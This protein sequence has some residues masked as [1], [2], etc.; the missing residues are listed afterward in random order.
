V[1]LQHRPIRQSKQH[2][3]T[4]CSTLQ[5][6]SPACSA[7]LR[8]VQELI[9]DWQ[10]YGQRGLKHNMAL[11][12]RGSSAGLPLLYAWIS[13]LSGKA[14]FLRHCCGF[15]ASPNCTASCWGCHPHS[16]GQI[17]WISR[18]TTCGM[19]LSRAVCLISITP[20]VPSMHPQCPPPGVSTPCIAGKQGGAAFPCGHKPLLRPAASWRV[21]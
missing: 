8:P 13:C 5:Q 3:K 16:R 17:L 1:P 6:C 12:S 14:A 21:G 2:P 15:G 10:Q 18:R 7:G 11:P 9:Y 19:T 20:L 4:T